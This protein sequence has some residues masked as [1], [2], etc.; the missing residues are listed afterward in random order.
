VPGTNVELKVGDLV[1][2]SGVGI[3]ARLS[4]NLSLNFMFYEMPT[5]QNKI[6]AV[7]NLLRINQLF[8]LPFIESRPGF[9]SWHKLSMDFGTVDLSKKN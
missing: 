1:S 7:I 3:Q 8:K 6:Q 9:E 4:T 2:I 5:E